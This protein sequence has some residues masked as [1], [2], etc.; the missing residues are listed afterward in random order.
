M[1]PFNNH[2]LF[3]D[4]LEDDFF[5]IYSLLRVLFSAA[6]VTLVGQ[7]V[8]TRRR[9]E[10]EVKT[11]SFYDLSTSSYTVSA[12]YSAKGAMTAVSLANADATVANDFGDVALDL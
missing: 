11:R 8:Q 12:A 4:E 5:P 10:G 7:R 1:D 6:F 3:S 9:R 2:V